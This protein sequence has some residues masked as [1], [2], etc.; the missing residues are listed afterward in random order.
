M[1]FLFDNHVYLSH[2]NC[3]LRTLTLPLPTLKTLILEDHRFDKVSHFDVTLENDDGNGTF[4]Q[5]CE[6]LEPHKFE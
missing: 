1:R 4:R 6:D 3:S 5:A 2:S